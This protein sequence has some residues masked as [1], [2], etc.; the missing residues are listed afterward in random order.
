MSLEPLKVRLRPLVANSL[1]RVLAGQTP[2]DLILDGVFSA[3]QAGAHLDRAGKKVAAGTYTLFADRASLERWKRPELRDAIVAALTTAAQE[4]GLPLDAPPLL[5]LVADSSRSAGAFRIAPSST[6]APSDATPAQPPPEEHAVLPE[7]AFLIVD[8]VKEFRLNQSRISIGRQLDNDLVVDD[9]RVSRHHAQ[10]RAIKGRYVL[11]D[12]NSSGGCF[13]N[14]Q[15]A[16][17][18]ILYPGD[19]LSLAGVSLIFG[20]DNPL[21]QRELGRTGPRSQAGADRRTAIIRA[22]PSPGKKER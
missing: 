12:L 7:K 11:F 20:Q 13:I 8:G 21:P 10:L 22:I 16:S 15:R 6:A 14:G 2:E 19:V 17:Q 18:S 3:V 4:A 5:T 9:P 1:V